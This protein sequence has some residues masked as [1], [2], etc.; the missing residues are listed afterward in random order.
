[1]THPIP[2]NW[3]KDTLKNLGVRII[4]GDRGKNYPKHHH[5]SAV[6]DC[7]FLNAGNVTK[8][9]FDF[10]EKQFISS[11]R[12]ALLSKGK[13]KRN[14]IVITTRGTVGN[15]AFYSDEI[16]Y[17][18][19]RINSGMAVIRN[20]NPR[21]K[22]EFLVHYFK[23][24]AFIKE[25]MRLSF[26]SAQLQLTIQII[27]RLSPFIPPPSEQHRIVAILET[28]DKA[29]ESLERKI[30]LKKKVKKGL[31]QKLLTARVRLPGFMENWKKVELGEVCKITMGQ[32]P[33]SKSYNEN[34]VG[35]PL[36]QGNNDIKK[37]K[38]IS[39]VWTSEITKTCNRD[40]IVMTV[41]A[42]VGCVGIAH[43]IVC[44]G[45]GVCAIRA[46]KVVHEFIY[47]ILE[48]FESRWKNL[49]QGSTFSAVNSSDIKTLDLKIP[50]SKE[51]QSAIAQI[52]ITA[53]NEINELSKKLVNLKE[54]KTHLLNHLITGRILTPENMPIS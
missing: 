9:G 28:W 31:M 19:I 16:E 22:T 30:E 26:G 24:P 1:M 14:D 3:Q 29:I 47:S 10:S 44:L 25:I 54:Q 6:G 42:P 33:P 37:R 52:I 32:S 5:F 43:E 23:S 38:T 21:I 15:T 53:D 39:R 20:Q 35:I 8:N 40:D 50:Q 45:R 27:N 4:D 36:I 17:E 51:E 11:E 18:N 49:E 48:F 2:Q 7:V 34:G 41:R 46:E 12:D 13:L